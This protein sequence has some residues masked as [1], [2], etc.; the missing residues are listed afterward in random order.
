MM[1]EK[2]I[3]VYKSNQE[4]IDPPTTELFGCG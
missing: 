3:K 2:K 1:I 4:S